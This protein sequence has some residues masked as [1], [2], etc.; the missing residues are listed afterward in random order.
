MIG[1]FTVFRQLKGAKAKQLDLE[2]ADIADIAINEDDNAEEDY[3]TKL[4]R[5]VQLTG[6][7][8]IYFYRRTI[9]TSRL[10]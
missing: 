8:V 6:S 5:L 7:S 4:S 10:L 1:E 3:S 9:Y 2:T